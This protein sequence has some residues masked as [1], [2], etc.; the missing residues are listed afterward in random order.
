M[1]FTSV[2]SHNQLNADRNSYALGLFAT[3]HEHRAVYIRQQCRGDEFERMVVFVPPSDS[4]SSRANLEYL[5]G[6]A[7]CEIFHVD[8]LTDDERIFSLLE[9][10]SASNLGTVLRIFIDYSSM[11]RLWYGAILNWAR[12]SEREKDIEIDFAYASG[13]YLDKFGPLPISELESLP[14]FE[15][16]SGGFRKTT[17]LF[18][19]GYD[20]YATLAVYDRIEPDVLYCCVACLTPND[21]S[22]FKARA[23]NHE[24]VEAAS[25]ILELPLMNVAST[26]R[27]LCDLI[28]SIERDSQIVVVP[29]GPKS[30]VLATL[31][32]ALRMPWITCLHAKGTR[33][34]PPQVDAVGPISVARVYFEPNA[35]N[36]TKNPFSQ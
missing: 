22:S 17:A 2:T 28:S 7:G 19:L 29:M 21:A 23:E 18:G 11:S 1:K 13:K 20:K 10:V 24:I 34:E 27:L 30:H 6:V 3:N 33:P 26:F 31:L 16:V 32:V 4:L 8:G 14:Y 5:S 15:G 9:E 12:F 25:S 35:G 36:S